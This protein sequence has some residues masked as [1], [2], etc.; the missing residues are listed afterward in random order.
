MGQKL[1]PI[2]YS[3][4]E[5]YNDA[6]KVLW[7]FNDGMGTHWEALRMTESGSFC[8]YGTILEGSDGC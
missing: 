5:E 3:D 8:R 6:E 7:V 1:F 2:I 4:M